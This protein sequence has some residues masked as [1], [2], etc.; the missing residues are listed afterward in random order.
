MSRS[1]KAHLRP[2]LP[3]PVGPLNLMTFATGGT[4][5]AGSQ[6]LTSYSMVK[7]QKQSFKITNKIRMS[8]PTIFIQD[9]LQVL[10]TTM[11]EEKAINGLQIGKKG[12]KLPLFADNIKPYT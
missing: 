10:T 5:R 6:Q 8:T 2:D 4:P 1:N 9:S 11:R 3:L 12:D 7:N